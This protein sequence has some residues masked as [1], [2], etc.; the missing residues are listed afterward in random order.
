MHVKEALENRRAYRALGP[1]EIT[2]ALLAELAGAARLMPSCFNNQPWKF[3]FARSPE[4][5]GK[6]RGCLSKNNDWARTAPLIAAVFGRKDHDC[7]INEREF[8]LFD[9]GMGV[10]ALLLRAAELGLVAHPIAGFNNELAREALGIP[11]GNLVITLLIIGKKTDD[12]SA[13]TPQQ[14]AAEPER[15][16][17]LAPENIYSVDAYDE[18]LAA[19]PQR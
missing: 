15:P 6:L 19:R 14:A 5:L 10:G 16:P 7:V 11:A 4:A 12:L 1:A 8:Y 17:R 18:K 2:D 9:L 13:L 3:V